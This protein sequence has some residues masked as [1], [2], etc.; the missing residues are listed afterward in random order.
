MLV[1]GASHLCLSWDSEISK[2][3]GYVRLVPR[4]CDRKGINKTEVKRQP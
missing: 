2:Q 1:I 3:K 4:A